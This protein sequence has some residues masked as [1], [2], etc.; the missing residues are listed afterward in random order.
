MTPN[1]ETIFYSKLYL[2]IFRPH[3][4]ALDGP[5]DAWPRPLAA[6]LAPLNAAIASIY[7][8]AALAA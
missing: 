8:E 5:P 2:R 6:A 7:Q 3:A 1:I 4:P